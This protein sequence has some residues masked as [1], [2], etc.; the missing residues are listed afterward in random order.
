MSINMNSKLNTLGWVVA[1]GL[2]GILLGGGFQNA[3]LKVGVVDVKAVVEKS[4]YFVNNQKTLETM[5]ANREGLLD[6]LFQ[7]KVATPDQMKRL[8]ELATK[9]TLTAQEKQEMDSLKNSIKDTDKDKQA[10]IQKASPT[11]EETAR[12]KGFQDRGREIDQALVQMR[13]EFEGDLQRKFADVQNTA[14]ERARTSINEVG[15]QG[16]YNILFRTDI[17]PYGANDVSDAALKSMN[18]KK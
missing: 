10:I 8:K 12:L 1:A 2:G 17:A 6:F 4:D 15:K 11:P 9:D 16:G 18:T 5:K 3:D 13:D 14:I 7:F